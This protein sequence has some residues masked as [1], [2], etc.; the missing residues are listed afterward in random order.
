VCSDFLSRYDADGEGFL[1]LS[2]YDADGEGF[3]SQ[4]VTGDEILIHHFE[5]QTKR[6]PMEWHH[7]ASSRGYPF[8]RESLLPLFLEGGCRRD[9]FV[10]H[11]PRG[12]TINSDLNINALKTLHKSFRGVRFTKMLLK[13]CFSTTTHKFES[14]GS[15]HKTRID[16]SA[17]STIQPRSCSFRSP[18]LWSPQRWHPWEK[19][20]E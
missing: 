14:T 16:C 20:W 15:N 8:S 18:P 2:R 5:P 13:P 1:S 4:I 19:V 10:R 7:A 17:P 9:D 3:L 12:Q 6:Q 11:M